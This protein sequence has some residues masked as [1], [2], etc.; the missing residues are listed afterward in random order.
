MARLASSI[1]KVLLGLGQV[2]LDFGISF[3]EFACLG[4]DAEGSACLA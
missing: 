1:G 4:L 2:R 3:F